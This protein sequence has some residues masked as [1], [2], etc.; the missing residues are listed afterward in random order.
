MLDVI[1]W[2]II[3]A[4]WIFGGAAFFDSNR[5]EY[6]HVLVGWTLLSALII[7]ITFLVIAVFWAME[8][9]LLV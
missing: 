9:I 5:T 8:R 2:I 1:A 3:G 6:K 4:L 7:V